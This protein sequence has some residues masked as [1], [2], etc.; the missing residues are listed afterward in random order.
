MEGRMS[1][2]QLVENL[3]ELPENERVYIRRHSTDWRIGYISQNEIDG[4]HWSTVSG[5][6]G[7]IASQPFIHGYVSCDR[8]RGEVSHSCAHGEGPHR[9]KVLIVKKD[10]TKEIFN[11]ACSF[12]GEKPRKAT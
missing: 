1:D 12:A 3:P 2:K 7:R 8:V 11:W 10:N 6:V 9:I 5:G 4:L